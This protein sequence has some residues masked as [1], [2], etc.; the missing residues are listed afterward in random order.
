M[1]VAERIASSYTYDD[2]E[3]DLSQLHHLLDVV[4]DIMLEMP[5][6]G[7]VEQRRV[8]ALVWIARDL[9][10]HLVEKIETAASVRH[11]DGAQ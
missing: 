7:N 4:V 6:D 5:H 1:S 10:E 9:A 11:P 3:S 2:L 8:D